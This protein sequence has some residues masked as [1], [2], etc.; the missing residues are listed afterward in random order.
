M[1]DLVLNLFV[2]FPTSFKIKQPIH[3]VNGNDVFQSLQFPDDQRPVRPRASEWYI[4]MITARF[5]LK[6]RRPISFNIKPSVQISLWLF[7]Q[8]NAHKQ[9]PIIIHY[10]K[11]N[12][13]SNLTTSANITSNPVSK[14]GLGPLESSLFVYDTFPWGPYVFQLYPFI[15]DWPLEDPD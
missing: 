14:G 4:Q 13:Y 9:N 5:R 1:L 8:N 12:P 11:G 15:H 7:T 2:E 3:D 10:M 6:S